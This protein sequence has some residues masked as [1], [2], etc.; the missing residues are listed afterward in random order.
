VN[1]IEGQSKSSEMVQFDRS[2]ITFY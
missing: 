1:D 2:Y